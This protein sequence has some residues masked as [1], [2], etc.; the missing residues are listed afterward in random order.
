MRLS[1]VRLELTRSL[2]QQLD[3]IGI[4]AGHLPLIHPFSMSINESVVEVSSDAA[5]DAGNRPPVSRRDLLD[6]IA[7]RDVF[8][9]LYID[10]TNRSIQA[11]QAAGRKRCSLKLHASLAALEE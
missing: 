4:G 2:L 11:Y 3:K 7:S 10:L 6:A 8:D 5:R 1:V 9:K